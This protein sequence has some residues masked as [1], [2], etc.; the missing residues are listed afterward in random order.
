[1]RHDDAVTSVSIEYT[2]AMD[3]TKIETWLGQLLNTRS[4]DIYRMKGVMTLDTGDGL[5]LERLAYQG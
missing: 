2:G 3:A 1:V 4:D 5:P